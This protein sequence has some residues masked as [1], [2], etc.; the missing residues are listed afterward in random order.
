MHPY[1]AL[2]RK[3][4]EEYILHR[5]VLPLPEEVP[6]DMKERNGVFVC[7]KSGQRS[8]RAASGRFSPHQRTS[9]RK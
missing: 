2:A 6:D 4:I 5:K 1:V 3:A 8:A 7:L 9:T